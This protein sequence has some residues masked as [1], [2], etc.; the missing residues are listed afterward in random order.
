MRHPGRLRRRLL[1]ALVA[2][3]CLG[4]TVTVPAGARVEPA[5]VAAAPAAPAAPLAPTNIA[6]RGSS[7]VGPAMTQWTADAYTRGL[8]VNY[9][10]TSSPDGLG[11]FQQS[12]VN[13]AGTEAEFSSLLG[14]GNDNQVRRGFQYVPD[15]AG[16]VA[17]MYN[18]TDRAGRKVDYLRLSRR[19]V[20][21][22]F[23]GEIS[24]WSDA[25]I[26]NDLGGGVVLPDEPITVVYRSGPSGTTALFYDF[27]QN[28]AP[29]EFDA[30]VARNRYPQG[31]RIIDP[32]V[33]PNFVPRGLG[34]AGS[35][36]MAQHTA[37]TPWTITY[38]EFAYA[39]RYNVNTAWI[40]NE[41]GQWVQPYAGNISAAL[42]SAQLRPDLSQELSG[43]Y[44][45][46][47]NGAYPISA[48]SYVVT[49]CAPA[50]DRPTC[51]GNYAD[52]RISETLDAWMQYIACDGQ[53]QMAEIGYSPLPPILSQ[54]MYKSVQ[55]MWGRPIS[56]AK[57]L[58]WDNCKNP[59]FDPNYRPPT[60]P[61]PPAL[62]DPP[63][64]DPGGDGTTGTT[65][66][67]DGG[68]DPSGA[69]GG[70]TTTTVDG[71]GDEVA[72]ARSGEVEAVGGGSGSW[73]DSDP[74][75]FKRRGPSAMSRWPLV[76]LVLLLA[77]PLAVGAVRARRRLRAQ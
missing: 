29:A 24:N 19:T 53:I 35:D 36:L 69:G 76:V 1:L 25:R 9:L 57:Q 40:Q 65:G 13:F 67:D 8:N 54:E 26:T 42:E 58:N 41:S 75:A 70:D 56:Q 18:V 15:V 30:W 39:K 55:R 7:Y 23:L 66:D 5:D 64:N 11:Q 21:L 72:A 27:V 16:A 10:P 71:G 6:G 3:A 51:K 47:E 14:L 59:R 12:T 62:P 31:V 38:D 33:S 48:Y 43:V 17:V 61:D 45:S 68:D 32:G 22:I 20:A 74:V 77:I 37:R 50:G 2:G 63:N 60:P 52:T 73:Q 4:G 34:L 49:Q 28:M 44:R 46:R